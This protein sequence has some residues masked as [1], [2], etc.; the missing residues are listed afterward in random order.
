MK[1]PW[2]RIEGPG[3]G[4]VLGI[5]LFLMFHLVT[6]RPL[7]H[8]AARD[9]QPIQVV[10]LELE[11]D[12]IFLSTCA[13]CHQSQGEGLA[14]QFPPLAASPYVTGDPETP[15]RIVLLGLQ[16]DIEVLGAR[17]NGTMPAQAHLTDEQ[18]ANVL[19]YVRS[20]FGNDAPEITTEQVVA[21]RESLGGRTT[22]LNG[23]AEVQALRGEGGA[24]P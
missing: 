4:A 13:A 10:P 16:G 15:I 3:L 11:G 7:V 21:V 17:Y 23:G 1:I 8:G 14:G 24:T 20:S 18:V 5:F 9:F 22:A 19:T 12:K 2:D 6:G